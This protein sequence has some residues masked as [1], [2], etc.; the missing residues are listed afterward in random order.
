VIRFGQEFCDARHDEARGFI[1]SHA[2]AIYVLRYRKRLAES[3]AD[4]ARNAGRPAQ[5]PIPV[6]RIDLGSG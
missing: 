5:W 3:D 4:A 2:F 6:D 1:C